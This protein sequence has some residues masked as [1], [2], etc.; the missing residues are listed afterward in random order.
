MEHDEVMR[1]LI[2]WTVILFL[3]GLLIASVYARDYKF[4]VLHPMYFLIELV[5]IGV[6][7]ALCIL[8]FIKSRNL[9]VHE[10]FLWTLVLAIKF[11]ILHVLLQLSGIYS[12]YFPRK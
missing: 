1:T 4:I 12:L 11:S 5:L 6:I 7:P 3:F 2:F 8:F 10:A 9:S